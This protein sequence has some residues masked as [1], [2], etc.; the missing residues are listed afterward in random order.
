MNRIAL[1]SALAALALAGPLA[2]QETGR[3]GQQGEYLAGVVAV[4]GDSIITNFEAQERLFAM[5]A[6]RQQEPP[7]PGPEYDRLLREVVD[8]RVT[9]LLLLQ[10]AVADTSLRVS[11]EE[12]N[13]A[14]DRYIEQLRRQLGGEAGLQRALAEQRRT[15]AAFRETLIQQQKSQALIGRYLQKVR[16]E[17][18]PPPVTD[19]EVSAL[20]DSSRDRVP[21]MPASITFEQVVLPVAPSD[22]ALAR[23]K[24]LADSLYQRIL[25]GDDF[26]ALARRF[27]ADPGSGQLGGDL[28]WFRQG[29]MYREFE[30]VAFRLRPGAV[31]PPVQTPLGFHIIKVERVRGAER[32]AR[33][34]LIRPEV[35][36]ADLERARAFAAQLADSIRAGA[37]VSDLAARYGDENEIVRVGP[38][39]R[40]SLPAPYADRLRDATAGQVV[41]PI[42]REVPN[43]LKTLAVVN[44]LRVEDARPATLEDFR[45]QLR[46]QIAQ[47]KLMDELVEEIRRQTHVDIRLAGVPPNR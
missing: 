7:P 12:I 44:V 43:G 20:F 17:R 30:D 18:K 24:T 41:G 47:Q 25:A 39:A 27:S 36:D 35:N 13:T 10:A 32:Q 42:E 1:A 40:D 8:Q 4:V 37:S 3:S 26:E 19:A 16:A 2:A 5:L 34:I 15:L 22:S 14:V 11:D 46:Q 31:S 6:Q 9:E 21:M 29:V 33:H 45:T 28:G 23:A 38:A